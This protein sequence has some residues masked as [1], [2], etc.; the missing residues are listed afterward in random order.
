MCVDITAIHVAVSYLNPF[1]KSFSFVK[2]AREQ[3]KLHGRMLSYLYSCQK[4]VILEMVQKTGEHSDKE[5][6]VVTKKAK[7]K[8]VVVIRQILRLKAEFLHY[9]SITG[10]DLTRCCEI[11]LRS[12]AVLKTTILQFSD[13]K[14]LSTTIAGDINFKH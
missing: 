9:N 11:S 2:D 10:V 5:D 6:D 12:F 1:L 14:L 3:K 13:F 4:I 8:N 7:Y